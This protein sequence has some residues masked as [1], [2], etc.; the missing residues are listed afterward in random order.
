MGEDRLGVGKRAL[1]GREVVV[2][3]SLWQ[4]DNGSN[5]KLRSDH[6]IP[7]SLDFKLRPCNEE[8]IDQNI[9]VESLSYEEKEWNLTTLD[10]QALK[11]ELL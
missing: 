1:S 10:H 4:M 9:R 8:L 6:W 2:Q 3:N 11:S 5:I 7:T